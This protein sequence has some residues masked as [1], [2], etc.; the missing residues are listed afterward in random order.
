MPEPIILCETEKE[1][2]DLLREL[3]GIHYAS[4]ESHLSLRQIAHWAVEH[5]FVYGNCCSHEAAR[6]RE[7]MQAL[8]RLGQWHFS[9]PKDER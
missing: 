5:T 9:I 6:L 8:D 7:E 4:A 1:F 2:R 3:L